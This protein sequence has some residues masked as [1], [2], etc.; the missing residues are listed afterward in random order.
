M[1]DRLVIHLSPEDIRFTS[2]SD[3]K[4]CMLRGGEVVFE[5]KGIDYCCFGR[6]CQN[7]G[8][9]PRMVISQAGSAEVNQRT[10]MWWDTPDELLEYMVGNDRLRDVITQVTV[11]DR[12]FS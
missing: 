8:E 10:E 9:K 4:M 11:W 7:P 3:F 2:I 12:P 1:S 6:L 5:W